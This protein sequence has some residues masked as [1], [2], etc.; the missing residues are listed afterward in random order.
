M[1]YGEVQEKEPNSH[2]H[3]I[4]NLS[5]VVSPFYINKQVPSMMLTGNGNRSFK[6]VFHLVMC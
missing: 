2:Q 6:I 5:N 3:I 4:C 1:D